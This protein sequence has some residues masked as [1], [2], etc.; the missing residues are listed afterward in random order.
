MAKDHADGDQAQ[1]HA[2]HR[3]DALDQ[4]GGAEQQQAEPPAAAAEVVDDRADADA[5]TAD[6]RQC[7]LQPVQPG[8]VRTHAG[9]KSSETTASLSLSRLSRSARCP[10]RSPSA[11]CT[12]P[13]ANAME[14]A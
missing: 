10:S 11:G 5:V 8:R 2:E 12:V 6:A 1:R 4:S 13:S 3:R 7:G 14:A 9:R